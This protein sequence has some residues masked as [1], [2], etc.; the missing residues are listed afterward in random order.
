MLGLCKRKRNSRK[1]TEK[2]QAGGVN[3]PVPPALFLLI[4]FWQAATEPFRA[5]ATVPG[6]MGYDGIGDKQ[7]AA[8]QVGVVQEYVARRV[9][10][11]REDV[12][13]VGVGRVGNGVAC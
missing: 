12:L 11:L 6:G 2:V 10:A 1:N 9:D 5:E 8:H 7:G 3:R 4:P 13:A